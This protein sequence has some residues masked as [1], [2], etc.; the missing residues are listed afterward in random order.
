MYSSPS[1]ST[2]QLVVSC[3]S[4]LLPSTYT[5][6]FV[7]FFF[8]ILFM[9]VLGLPCCVGFSFPQLQR[10][11][12]VLQ[13][14]CMG[15]SLR[16]RLLLRSLGYSAHRLPQL[17]HVGSVVAAP[18]LQ[19]TGLIFVVPR[20][21]CSMACGIFLDQGSNCPCFLHWQVDSLPLTHQGSSLLYSFE[22][23]SRKSI[24]STINTF[25]QLKY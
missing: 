23:N 13:L 6:V 19:S 8:L 10:V 21:N 12:A 22:T 2:Y 9:A 17:R 24:I 14:Q 1:F 5:V 25:I 16:W 15:F 20:L 4:C 11:G 3:V 7:F 18:R